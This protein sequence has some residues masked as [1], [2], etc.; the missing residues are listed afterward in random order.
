MRSAGCGFLPALLFGACLLIDCFS[1]LAFPVPVVLDTK[2]AVQTNSLLAPFG[3]CAGATAMR[4]A[5]R[6]GGGRRGGGRGR[7]GKGG[8]MGGGAANREASLGQFESHFTSVFK[9]RWPALKA[10]LANP[11]EHVAW[12]SPFAG[13]EARRSFDPAHWSACE[14]KSR[15]TLMT[16]LPGE[17]VPMPEAVPSAEKSGLASHYVLDGASPLPALALA[18]RPGHRVLDLCAAP[19]GKSLVLAGQIFAAALAPDCDKA[20]GEGTG[21][22][23]DG[24]SD[25]EYLWP[26][27]RSLLISNDR[28]GPRR[29][30]LRR[31][32][33]EFV[34]STLIR[35][36]SELPAATWGGEHA[37]YS[38]AVGGAGD[39]ACAVTGVDATAWG[40]GPA[41]PAW[42]AAGFDRVLVD[43]PCSSERHFLQGAA[44]AVW[45]R[46]RLKR[47]AE[48]QGA[49]LR[50]A[51]RMLAVGGRLVYSTCSLADEENDSVVTKLLNH[52]RHG[53]GLH[54]V[55]ALGG[56]LSDDSIAPLLHGVARTRCGAMMLPDTSRFGPLYWAVI[57]RRGAANDG[58]IR[59]TAEEDESEDESVDQDDDQRGSDL[60]GGGGETDE[61]PIE[62]R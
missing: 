2:E 30:R 7:G 24:G 27:S 9:G 58:A 49:I 59:G 53:A 41:A 16:R 25:G 39:G 28:S 32:I 21:T 11:V 57:E 51:V 26:T 38:R 62:V 54:L 60:E 19:G 6:G 10:A 35:E 29:A 43:A 22:G 48:L 18:P 13:A 31:V 37:N 5:R 20:D 4:A 3:K 34:P 1:G 46:A 17:Q 36:P 61:E 44:D 15:C 56:P 40:R 42:S 12:V 47:D 8:G 50:N 33:E 45:S 52:A 14:H 55:D 23:G